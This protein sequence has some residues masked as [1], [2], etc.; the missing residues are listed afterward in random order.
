MKRIR[1]T[2]KLGALLSVAFIIFGIVAIAIPLDIVVFQNK[3]AVKSALFPC[4]PPY[5]LSETGSRLFG[6]LCVVLGLMLGWLSWERPR[7]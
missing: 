5:E 3:C 7:K 1:F 4:G 2:S 6:V